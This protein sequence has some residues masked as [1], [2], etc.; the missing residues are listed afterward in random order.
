[1]SNKNISSLH[2]LN[3][4]HEWQDKDF[5]TAAAQHWQPVLEKRK[6]LLQDYGEFE[7]APISI[8]KQIVKIEQEYFDEWGSEG[9]LITS[10]KKRQKA[11]RMA[12]TLRRNLEQN[13]EKEKDHER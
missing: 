6:E 11:E 4:K 3:I 8:Q 9:R 13:R 12:V 1:M 2:E 5:A 10:L 7:D